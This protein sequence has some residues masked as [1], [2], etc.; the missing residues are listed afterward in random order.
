TLKLFE[1]ALRALHDRPLLVIGLARPSAL[2]RFPRLWADR[3]VQLVALRELTRKNATL[4]VRA[5]LG[6]ADGD[7]VRRILD[8][9]GG[10]PRYLEE[11][12]AA[13]LAGS[14]MLPETVAMMV[15]SRLEGLG[16]DARRVLR[17]ASVFGDTFWRG[18][19]EAL[20]GPEHRSAA[21]A[22]LPDLVEREILVRR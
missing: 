5:R 11:L 4:L 21:L 17:A 18:G 15:E 1:Y 8:R 12:V 22:W 20:L 14:T 6:D 10:N 16:T 13:E 9:G 19:V 7:R 2:D 3:G